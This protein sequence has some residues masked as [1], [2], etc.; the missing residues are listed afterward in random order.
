MEAKEREAALN[1]EE[2]FKKLRDKTDREE[3]SELKHGLMGGLK[4]KDV[5]VFV[6][7]LKDQ[8]QTAERTYKNRISELTGERDQLRDERDDLQS[9]LDELVPVS[10]LSALSMELS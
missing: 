5:E 8:M 10:S 4:P 2:E 1:P 3:L 6:A 9:R 7:R